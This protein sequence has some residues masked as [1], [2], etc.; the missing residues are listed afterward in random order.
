MLRY[1]HR[2]ALHKR[3]ASK[4]TRMPAAPP[5]AR[6]LQRRGTPHKVGA[7]ETTSL[8]AT[9]PPTRQHEEWGALHVRGTA[10]TTRVFAASPS[11]R[12]HRH[13]GTLRQRGAAGSTCLSAAAPPPDRHE[14]RSTHE[15]SGAA[16]ASPDALGAHAHLCI[17]RRHAS[18]AVSSVSPRRPTDFI[19]II[20][21][22]RARSELGRCDRGGRAPHRPP[23]TPP[24]GFPSFPAGARN[25]EHLSH[26]TPV[27]HTQCIDGRVATV[28]ADPEKSGRP[29]YDWVA[30]VGADGAE[31]LGRALAVV[32]ALIGVV[33]RT[34]VVERVT[35]A[36]SEEDFPFAAYRCK[37][38]QW[39][40]SHG[41]TTAALEAVPLADIRKVLCAGHDWDDWVSRHGLGWL[42][43]PFPLRAADVSNRRFFKTAFVRGVREF[44]P[45]SA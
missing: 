30:C 36:K 17:A 10:E 18:N 25:N 12:R 32:A 27:A 16:H 8:A 28:S 45:C 39:A 40:F 24:L 6:K 2:G 22:H 13:N 23:P 38:M 21:L 15:L 1:K 29:L 44:L 11:S 19:M 33:E 43:H 37:R 14:P 9:S 31:Q 35:A 42:P 7:A 34:F 5:S 26:I 3:G 4:T 20:A 41:D